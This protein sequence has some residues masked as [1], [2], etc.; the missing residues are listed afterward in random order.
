M[1]SLLPN[2]G[3]LIPNSTSRLT[4][5]WHHMK[6]EYYEKVYY[7]RQACGP[8]LEYKSDII[9]LFTPILA[10]STSH[11]LQGKE[12]SQIGTYVKARGQSFLGLFG[13]MWGTEQA[14]LLARYG[15]SMV[16]LWP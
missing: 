16:Q 9:Y 14:R 15:R 2:G 11:V 3:A 5:T 1:P 7:M 12:V 6:R 13:P 4:Y 10:P 8:D